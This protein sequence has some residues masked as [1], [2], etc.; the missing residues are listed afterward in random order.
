LHTAYLK[1]VIVSLKKG[2]YVVRTGKLSLLD[3]DNAE[4]GMKVM[5]DGGKL[6]NCPLAIARVAPLV[7]G[8]EDW[9]V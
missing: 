9:L 2:I 8:G 7:Y 4:P 3:V 1:P 5:V 6:L